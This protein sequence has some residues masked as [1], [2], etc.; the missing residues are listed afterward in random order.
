MS[1]RLLSNAATSYVR[2]GT[3]FA[4]GL[5][6]TWYVLG[7]AGVIGFGMIALAV[8][9]TGPSHAVERTLRFGLVRELAA[10]I[11]SGEPRQIQR[12]LTSA[13]RL[14]LQA[15]VLLA[16]VVLLLSWAAWAGFFNIPGDQQGLRLALAILILGE[17]V[18]AAVRLLSAPHVQSLFAAQHVA[19][20][21]LLMVVARAT[22][23]LSAVVIF[24][25]ML[26]KAS[27][28]TQLIAF[29]VSRATV[30]LAD[31]ALG[32]WLAK[33]LVPGLRL[34]RS[35][36]DEAEYLSVRDTVW[37]S[38]QVAVLLNTIPQF[39]AILINLFFGLTYNG[40]WQI[41][42]QF[43]GFA[44]MFSQGLLRGIEPLTTHLQQGGRLGMAINLMARSI[45]YQLAIALPASVFLCL[46][47]RPLL[48][49]WVGRR[50]AA[51][52]GLAAAGVPV[53]E[54][55]N[56]AATMAVILIVAQTFRA[57]FFGVERGL[58][59]IGKVRS[60]AWFSKWA[61]LIAVGSAAGLMAWFRQPVVA[62]VAILLSHVIFSPGV[63]VSAARREVGL[64]IAATLR[65]TFPRPLLANFAFLG[66]LTPLRLSLDRLTLVSLGTLLAGS[67]LA[68]GALALLLIPVADERSR[69]LQLFGRGVRWRARRPPPA[70]AGPPRST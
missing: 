68:Y 26:P 16:A 5:F 6:T 54:A 53:A 31:V 57:G 64:P 14:C 63:V 9:S 32:I 39:I 2:L 35:T 25:W 56:L 8:S 48:D 7:A 23:A 43:S 18:H 49:L 46:F 22:Y 4:F 60:Y 61:T 13:F 10:A 69:L 36:Y 62:P 15:T 1:T 67:A 41:V 50:L 33:R 47:V 17:G 59:G 34:D 66:F 24:G 58:Y 52:A 55:L 3:T 42:V 38:S 45:R 70:Q 44:W 19:V 29:A 21:N 28:S 30:Q 37:Q 11:A 12:S 20:D 51:D 65:S 40:I 27:L